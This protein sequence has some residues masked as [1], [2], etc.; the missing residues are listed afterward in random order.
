M[1]IGVGGIKPGG[2]VP[3]EELENGKDGIDVGDIHGE[4][5]KEIVWKTLDII[6]SWVLYFKLCCEVSISY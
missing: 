6:W 4:A 1:K 3:E 5:E 2:K